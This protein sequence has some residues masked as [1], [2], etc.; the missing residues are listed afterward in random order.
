MFVHNHNFEPWF[1][2]SHRRHGLKAVEK[3]AKMGEKKVGPIYNVLMV[4]DFNSPFK[5]RF[6]LPCEQPQ[7]KLFGGCLIVMSEPRPQQ[8]D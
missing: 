2:H 3:P 4:Q 7:A 8:I 6:V 1:I 5:S